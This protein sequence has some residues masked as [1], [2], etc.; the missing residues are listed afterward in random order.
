MAPETESSTQPAETAEQIQQALHNLLDS[1]QANRHLKLLGVIESDDIVFTNW[2][3]V[4][5]EMDAMYE[6]LRATDAEPRIAGDDYNFGFIPGKPKLVP[7]GWTGWIDTGS[8]DPNL[9]C[10]WRQEVFGSK[11]AE[12]QSN[13]ALIA[14][15][16]SGIDL[17]EAKRIV[18]A[19]GMPEPTFI[20]NTGG[21]GFHFYWVYT[22][23]L[24]PQQ[25][26]LLMRR[27]I[28][29]FKPHPR[30]GIDTQLHNPNRVMRIAGSIHAGTGKRATIIEETGNRFTAEDF[31]FLPPVNAAVT[32]FD[33]KRSELDPETLTRFGQ[34][35]I[36]LLKHIDAAPS[37]EALDAVTQN[38]YG[39][40]LKTGWALKEC[41]LTVDVWDEWSQGDPDKYDPG[42]CAAKWDTFDPMASNPLAWLDTAAKA[43]GYDWHA[44]LSGWLGK[45][46]RAG[47]QAAVDAAREKKA[48]WDH[49][50]DYEIDDTETVE[51][52]CEK[53]IR[54]KLE[55]AGS[56]AIYFNGVLRRYDP[57]TGHYRPW[58]LSE[59]KGDIGSILAR[60]YNWKKKG[61]DFVPVFKN[62]TTPIRTRC[63]DW[64]GPQLY[65]DS[66]D[67][68]PKQA[69]AFRNCTLV[70]TA[71]GWVP[72]P[73][74]KANQLTHGID[75]DYVENAECPPLFK[76]FI[77][78]SFGLQWLEVWRALIHYHANPLY[79]CRV[80]LFILGQSGSG[81]GVALRLLQKIY[82][83]DQI[84]SLNNF[85]AIDTPE[86]LAQHV[87][88]SYLICFPDLQGR[89][90]AGVGSLYPLADYG[91]VFSGRDL[92][93]KEPLRFKFRGRVIIASTQLPNLKDAN[94]G[95]KRRIMPIPTLEKRLPSDVIPSDPQMVDLW[96]DDLAAELGQ[97]ISWAMAMPEADVAKIL[98]KDHPELKAARKAVDANIDSLHSFVDQCLEPADGDTVADLNDFYSAY[99]CF[100]VVVGQKAPL[101]FHSF[102][103]RLKQILP[104]LHRE[105]SGGG[106]SKARIPARYIG[107][108]LLPG[109][110]SRL[111]HEFSIKAD[112]VSA[113]QGNHGW[114]LRSKLIDGQLELL[115]EHNP[116]SSNSMTAPAETPE[117]P[118][119]DPSEAIAAED[120]W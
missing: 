97:I 50:F 7:K 92:F 30:F 65:V 49:D 117:E 99:C 18:N 28:E 23:P 78:T 1:E 6:R 36:D 100:L 87:A 60:F 31:T 74:S 25:H 104:Q 115:E 89:Q 19:I 56:D 15:C 103:M 79:H 70:K 9:Q 47:I 118:I 88:K 96:E 58:P 53:A 2:R 29:A 66:I 69:I 33:D 37:A 80:F 105:R 12:I 61:D 54:K 75:H 85:S 34:E 83:V 63:A 41:G 68:K 108:R 35:A 113:Y 42:A 120:D 3:K 94:S 5:G 72:Q 59:M 95:F 55:H 13:P 82:N 11:K 38:S 71:E 44:Q 8:W 57:S 45:A 67:Y 27:L 86:K 116:A 21:R 101:S 114:L 51:L 46:D 43:C 24:D 84:T 112:A 73:H 110:W 107:V 76:E 20:I 90:D 39:W 102:K 16:D 64:L 14:D 52:K 81:K 4:A 17:A 40:W 91:Q 62:A 106:N 93:S 109:L 32:E 77:R 98:A 48:R 119:T 22:T 111:E 10:L 26:T